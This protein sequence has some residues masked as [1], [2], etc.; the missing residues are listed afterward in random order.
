MIL[1]GLWN[2]MHHLQNIPLQNYGTGK[3]HH[4][5]TWIFFLCSDISCICNNDVLYLFI[6]TLDKTRLMQIN[7]V[8]YK[9]NLCNNN[10]AKQPSRRCG[11]LRVLCLLMLWLICLQNWLNLTSIVCAMCIKEALNLLPTIP[12][13]T[14]F[15][16]LINLSFIL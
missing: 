9:L 7:N 11:V 5:E 14:R 8:K 13:L 2:P 1:P 4:L 6:L 16:G 15:N 12:I 10:P 3:K